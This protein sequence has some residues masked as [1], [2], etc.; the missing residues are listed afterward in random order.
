VCDRRVHVRFQFTSTLERPALG[1]RGL[2]YRFGV[3]PHSRALAM[4]DPALVIEALYLLCCQRRED[5]MI[6]RLFWTANLAVMVA[7]VVGGGVAI[8]YVVYR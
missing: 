7:I 6:E 3:R 2:L 5:Q 1:R 4:G 8:V